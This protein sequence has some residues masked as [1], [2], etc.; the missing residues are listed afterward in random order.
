MAPPRKPSRD[1]LTWGSYG[2]HLKKSTWPKK[3]LR[4]CVH[5]Q[6]KTVQVDRVMSA[7]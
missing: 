3:I 2:S 5:A 7:T 6:N 1:K 4:K